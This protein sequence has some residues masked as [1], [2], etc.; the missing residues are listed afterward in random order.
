[1]RLMSTTLTSALLFA[2]S[3]AAPGA[4]QNPRSL[5]AASGPV[6]TIDFGAVDAK[7][8]PVTDLSPG[9]VT[10][11]IDNKPRAVRTLQVVK[12]D[13]PAPLGALPSDPLPSPFASNVS[14]GGAGRAV[15]VIFDSETMA[16]GREQRIRDAVTTLING[17]GPRDQASIVTVP[18]GGVSI[19]YTADRAK[20]LEATA[21]LMGTA[22]TT[23][24]ADD[25]ACRSRL[26]V[27]AITG[28]LAQRA[29]AETPVDVILVSSSLVGPRASGA[30][31]GRGSV[32]ACELR[33]DE[34]TKLGLA[35]AS[36]RARF[37]IVQPEQVRATTTV[38]ALD[39]PLAGL[40]NVA[41]LTGGYIWH[42]AGSDEPSFQRVAL[43]TS[44]YY[45]ATVELDPA[46]ANAP[47]RQLSVKTTRPDVTIRS[48]PSIAFA[49]SATG[50]RSGAAP[51]PKDMMKSATSYSDVP[52][53]LAAFP[54]RNPGDGKIKI[55]AIA[56]A[57]AGTKLSAASIGLYDQSGKLVGQ[58]SAN[59]TEL[60]STS[61]VAVFVQPAG[62]YRARVA[63][64]DT[65]G[66][67]GTADYDVNST[68]TTAA[69][70]LTLS[71]MLL[72]TPDNTFTPKLQFTN[73]PDAVA[74]FELY[75]GKPGMPVSVA[76]E[77]AST[78]NGPANATLQPKISASSSRQIHH[79]DAHRA[80][81]VASWRLPFA[82]L[83][84]LMG[85]RQGGSW[86]L[87]AR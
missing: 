13:G 76:M 38:G 24:T 81:P 15:L 22:P 36:A 73:E 55:V 54:S 28:L 63:A 86:T 60:A 44:S 77:L 40:E 14:S 21:K 71:S 58:W 62:Q 1:M 27:Q 68:L 30:T 37:H 56:E 6:L 72:G 26:T 70:V 34:F 45:T 79:H 41:S 50:G 12:H 78:L 25:A 84:D 48:R 11:R 5:G 59:A 87:E 49:R 51:A 46:D 74:Y 83:S 18:R 19:N 8:H 66:R 57:S 9:D 35:A 10:I 47:S 20:L 69:G 43:E 3:A 39:S 2:L 85:N 65:A 17:L 42:M 75:G 29:G 52:L 82:R 23:E 53:R 33:N 4:Q 61:L 64:T 67:A 7:G 32:G 16:T 31:L 80:R